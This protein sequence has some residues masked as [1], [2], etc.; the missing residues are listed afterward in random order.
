MVGL[1]LVVAGD[2]EG[3][4][5]VTIFENVRLDDEI[6]ADHGFDW[7]AAAVNQRLEVLDDRAGKSPRHADMNQLKLAQ[8]ER[9]N[10]A[11][12]TK[13]DPHSRQEAADCNQSTRRGE[14]LLPS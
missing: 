2:L 4:D 9:G 14:L 5:V 8:C 1:R 3:D 7:I 13:I 11:R 12:S 10:R 6:F